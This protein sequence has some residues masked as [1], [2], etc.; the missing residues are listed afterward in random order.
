M[1]FCL[2][3]DVS[4]FTAKRDGTGDL[5]FAIFVRDTVSESLLETFIIKK[6][7]R[8]KDSGRQTLLM[9]AMDANELPKLIPM[10]VCAD[11]MSTTG[12]PFG[13]WPLRAIFCGCG[14]CRWAGGS[15]TRQMP[16]DDD[17]MRD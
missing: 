3:A 17:Q 4:F 11:G 7:V 14:Y 2:V 1:R 5:A 13:I 16:A 12:P 9:T 10:T 15:W 6:R 8:A